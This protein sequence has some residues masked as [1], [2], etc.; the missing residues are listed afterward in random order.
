MEFITSAGRSTFSEH[1]LETGYDMWLKEEIKTIF[2][3]E[4]DSKRINTWRNRDYER[5]PFLP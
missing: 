1:V 3:F 5:N 2:H 4:N